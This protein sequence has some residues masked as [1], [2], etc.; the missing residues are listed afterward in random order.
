M[1]SLVCGVCSVFVFLWS[2]AVH[3]DDDTSTPPPKARAGALLRDGVGAMGE[4]DFVTALDRFERAYA[5]YPSP[6]LLVNI[7]TTLRHLGR[8]AEAAEAYRRYIDDPGAEPGRVKELQRILSEIELVTATVELRVT[9]SNPTVRIDE[10]PVALTG[11]WTTIVVDPGDH[12]L[13]LLTPSGES[14]VKP[15]SVVAGDVVRLGLEIPPRP[16]VPPEIVVLTD[17]SW[18]QPT[19][20][21]SVFGVGVGG[22]IGG[23]ALGLMANASN[24][25]AAD[26]CSSAQPGVCDEAGAALGNEAETQSTLSTVSFIAGGALASVGLVVV[27]TSPGD[28]EPPSASAT[29]SP[30][31]LHFNWTW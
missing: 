27:L 4:L 22:L 9:A 8:N 26:Q 17:Q 2:V 12:T 20:G 11:R 7:G 1:R 6:K 28:T 10:R 13:T 30:Q 29:L 31:G 5:L 24:D 16:Q 18:V 15:F 21:W 25:S 23:G 14:S 19:I 3:A